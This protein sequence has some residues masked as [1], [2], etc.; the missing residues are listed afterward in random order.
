MKTKLSQFMS[1]SMAGSRSASLGG[2]GLVGI[3]A[4]VSV[5]PGQLYAQADAD[6]N[7]PGALE[8][9]LVTAQ[10]RKE[11]LQEVPI[12]VAAVTAESLENN[13][14]D[15]TRDLPQMVPSVQFTRS[16]A[17]GL[18]FIRGVGTT[19]GAA[20]EESANAVY[21]DGVYLADL[22]QA[23]NN[24]NNIERIEVLKGPQGT[25]FGRNATGG[26]V[27][28]ITREPGDELVASTEIGYANYETISGRAYIGGPISDKFSA[29]VAVTKLDQNDGWG[30]NLTLNRD[31]KLQDNWGVRSKLVMRA[32]D[33]LKLTLAGDY[34][35]NNDNLALGY[36]LDPGTVGTGGFTGPAGQD[37]TLNDYPST[38]QK[39]YGGSLT[40]EAD[41]G[42]ATLTSISAARRSRNQSDFDVDA[43]PN[44]LIRIAFDSGVKALQQELRLA[45]N[46]TEPVSWQAGLFYLH[47]EA[48][49]NSNFT[50]LQF[51]PAGLRG[52]HI[53]ANL[54]T[55][56]YA[57]FAEATY[58]ITPSTKL[59]GGVRYTEDHRDFDGGQ[60]PVSLAGVEGA[61][62]KNAI[63]KLDY[64]AVTYR[65][66]VLQ[67][68][69]E[70]FNVYASFNRG[71]KSGSYSLQS[72]LNAPYLP[73]YIKAYEIGAKSEL[74]SRKLRV[75]VSAYHY[76]IDDYQVR[77]AAAV[78]PGSSLILN[79]ATVKVDGV[80]LEIEAAPTN[81]LRLFGG[82][83]YLD[84]R[85]DKFGGANTTFQ[86]PIVYPNPA[87]CP[88]GLRGTRDP[89]VLGAGARTGGFTTCFG[90]VSGNDTPNAP[91][92]TGNVGVSY[93][94]P[95][96][97][98]SEVR[99]SVLYSYNDGYVFESDNIAKQDSYDLLN[100]SLEF[101]LKDYGIELWGRNLGDT[102]YAIQ[103]ITSSTGAVATLGAPRTYGVSLKFDF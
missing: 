24:F 91:E 50:G 45:S 39:I 55:D 33:T 48:Q 9:I 61:F 47:P 97:L 23:I 99:G 100:A 4:M 16:G 90:D 29:D 19:N 46:E 76:D 78:N 82:I 1:A 20:G 7:A 68:I 85:F 37:T 80:D 28:I 72:P 62:A 12:A 67:K 2:L 13:G 40:I 73:Q 66:S 22:A 43:G 27:Q 25:L 87:T 3:A 69:T 36:K 17:S 60:A 94:I 51:A 63:T 26:L 92:L 81:T 103:K 64:D 11:P 58:S 95:L 52:Q 54:E 83:T 14:I 102:E 5:F 30:R 15:T 21:V 53:V 34:Y 75:N 31:N 59:T 10:R 71:F 79:A 89:G 93:T 98:T 35:E 77:S 44:P 65:L 6:A 56:S 84:S 101:R 49:N 86:A 38:E 96:G 70:D 8:E 57:A 32:S 42:F 41:M 88:A 74:L 18:L